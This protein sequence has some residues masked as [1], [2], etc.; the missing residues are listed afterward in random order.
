MKTIS[1]KD[2][3]LPELRI[4]CRERSL[5]PGG[6]KPSLVERLTDAIAAGACAPLGVKNDAVSAG[7]RPGATTT[8]EQQVPMKQGRVVYFT[9]HYI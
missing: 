4:A 7:A 3:T 9:P 6:S 1:P 5:N 2:L 8:A